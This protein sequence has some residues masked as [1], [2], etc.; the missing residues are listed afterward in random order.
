MEVAIQ[1]LNL[2]QI[3]DPEIHGETEAAQEEDIEEDGNEEIAEAEVEDIGVSLRT[4]PERPTKFLTGLKGRPRKR[5][6]PYQ[7]QHADLITNSEEAYLAEVPTKQAMSGPDGKDGYR[8][9][10]AK[11]VN[12][13]K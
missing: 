5:Y 6:H 3:P 8:V 12:N 9:I 4:G 13:K 1:P 2:N 11:V 10:A 7:E